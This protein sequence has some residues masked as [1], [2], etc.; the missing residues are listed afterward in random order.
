MDRTLQLVLL[1]A[2]VVLTCMVLVFGPLAAVC[3]TLAWLL[4]FVVVAIIMGL[5]AQREADS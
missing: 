2:L 1:A 3:I 5:E 4:W